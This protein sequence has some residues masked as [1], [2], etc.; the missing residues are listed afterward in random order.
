MKNLNEG[1]KAGDLSELVL[2]LVSIDEYESKLD[3]DSIVIG[4]FIHDKEPAQDLNRFIQKGAVNILDTDVSPAP[5]ED[6][7]FVVFVELLRDS[8]SPEKILSILSTLEGLTDIKKWRGIFYG[9]EN[10][11]EITRESLNQNMRLQSTEDHEGHDDDVDDS[12]QDVKEWFMLSDLNG[13]LIE[14]STVTL[15]GIKTQIDLTL[16]DF[17]DFNTLKERNEV[18]SQPLRMDESAQRNMTRIHALL[19][20]RWLVEHLHS[21]VLLSNVDSSNVGLFRIQ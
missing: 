21:H 10:T 4:F 9:K 17:G 14:N 20:D 13:L 8:N 19:G 1:L 2:P 18:L 5:N 6:G 12:D 7:Y 15:Q 16:V 11:I 3:D